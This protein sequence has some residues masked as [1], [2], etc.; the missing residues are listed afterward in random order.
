MWQN[1]LWYLDCVEQK[2]GG[3]H[4][5]IGCWNGFSPASN[6][7]ETTFNNHHHRVVVKSSLEWHGF[8]CRGFDAGSKLF[9]NIQQH[10]QKGAQTGFSGYFIRSTHL[11]NILTSNKRPDIRDPYHLARHARGVG[12]IVKSELLMQILAYN[13]LYCVENQI[14]SCYLHKII[15]PRHVTASLE[16]SRYGVNID[17]WIITSVWNI[18]WQI[19][20]I[21]HIPSIYHVSFVNMEKAALTIPEPTLSQRSFLTLNCGLN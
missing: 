8:E 16:K 2:R 18:Y 4:N 12:S 9:N 20:S 17:I 7:P 6:S 10:R 15:K 5:D 19:V 11:L 13:Y 21:T 1:D 3:I 14:N